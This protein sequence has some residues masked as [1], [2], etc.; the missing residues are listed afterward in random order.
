MKP[1]RVAII[2]A[3]R[4]PIGKFLGAFRNLSAVDLGAS[5]VNAVVERS[6]VAPG[7]VDEFIFGNARQAGGGPNPARQIAHRAGIPQEVPAYTVN[8]ACAS[9]CK[10]IALAFDAITWRGASCVV[11]GG[12]ENMTRV[13]FLL[14][15]ARLGYRLGHAQL[16]D[17]MYRD[18]FMDP[19]SELLMGETAEVLADEY[20]IDR[21]AQDRYALMSQERVAESRDILAEEILPVM[22]PDDRGRP[23]EV[24]A[25]E[26]P[27]SGL[28]LEGLAKLAPV[29]RQDGTVTAGN[30][31]GITDGAAALVLVSEERAGQLGKRPLGFVR[32]YTMVGVDPK[33]MG[34]G[35]VPVTRKIL[36]RN[37]LELGDI[38]LI[39][40]NEAF[41]AQV[42][43]CQ[44]DL[45]LDLERV[46]V[47]GGAISLGHPIGATGA[48]I[49]VTLL[50]EM[51][52]REAEMGLATL[53][54]SG[55][56]GMALLI[57]KN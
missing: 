55:G 20:H 6:G 46:N 42:L 19:L 2:E 15:S 49:V 24:S 38:P 32:D 7:D 22:A 45:E 47:R 9:G 48:R 51:N 28:T 26:H 10:A 33:R 43:A 30:A 1:P 53:C 34:I 56:L 39:E 5:V 52:R 35:P 25:D 50:H 4:T 14:D 3:K 27:R 23:V 57:D 37:N 17:G 8:M 12:T 11:A 36:E 16:I 29:F 18:G 13:P 31:S 41:A 54:V 40:L 21:E 44:K